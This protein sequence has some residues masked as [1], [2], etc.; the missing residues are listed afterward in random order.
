MFVIWNYFFYLH[1]LTTYLLAFEWLIAH[2]LLS[3][4]LMAWCPIHRSPSQCHLTKYLLAFEWLIAHDPL[5]VVLMEWC[6]IHRAP[7][8]CHFMAINW[9]PRIQEFQT[10]KLFDS[11][12]YIYC[13]YITSDFLQ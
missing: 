4:V 13:P 3:V 10:L 8:Q 11:C 2:D 6:P 9:Y 1:H 7:S 5:S 12:V